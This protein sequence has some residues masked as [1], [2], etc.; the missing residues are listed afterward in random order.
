[1]SEGKVLDDVDGLNDLKLL[2]DISG[3]G[4]EVPDPYELTEANN[5]VGLDELEELLVSDQRRLDDVDGLN[6]LKLLNDNSDCDTQYSK[7]LVDSS[8]WE[9]IMKQSFAI[10]FADL[11]LDE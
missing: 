1:M 5:L 2:N 9:I 7:D 11:K 8:L 4:I 3:D 10:T 6:D